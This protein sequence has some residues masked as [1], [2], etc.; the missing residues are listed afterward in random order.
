[1]CD[2]ILTQNSPLSMIQSW[3]SLYKEGSDYRIVL[4]QRTVNKIKSC[5]IEN[6][7]DKRHSLGVIK[8]IILLRNTEIKYLGVFVTPAILEEG[9][10]FQF[11][12][13]WGTFGGT[14]CQWRGGPPTK[15]CS[16]LFKVRSF[17]TKTPFPSSTQAN[18]ENYLSSSSHPSQAKITWG[19]RRVRPV[20]GKE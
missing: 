9:N 1:M 12:R 8:K 11:K 19:G 16:W 2:L 14:E 20:R 6:I 5:T 17:H 18:K 10:H 3:L 7:C 13:S 15:M 4:V